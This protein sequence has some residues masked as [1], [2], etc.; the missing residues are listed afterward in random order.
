MFSNAIKSSQLTPN[1]AREA[2]GRDA[3]SGGDQLYGDINMVP[4]DSVAQI[5]LAKYLSSEGEKVLQS[6]DVLGL[7]T[8]ELVDSEPNT[9]IKDKDNSNTDNEQETQPAS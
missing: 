6:G 3:M 9:I 1:E 7:N 2:M 8:E 4:L 5:A